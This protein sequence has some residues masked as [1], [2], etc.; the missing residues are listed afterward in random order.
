M[1]NKETALRKRTQ[2]SKANRTMFLWVAGASVVVG[3]AVVSA[4]FIVQILIFN[5]KV[6]AEK[7]NTIA[8]LRENN[9]NIAE[10]QSQVRA[11]DANASLATSKASETDQSLQVVLDALPSDANSLAL[12]A[13]LQNKLL[14]GIPGLTVVSLRVTPVFG[15]ETNNAVSSDGEALDGEISFQFS[16]SGDESSLR[17]ALENLEKS[18]RTIHIDHLRVESQGSTRV[19]DVQARAF[20]EPARVVEL[21]N[22]TVR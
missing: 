20:Y 16:V 11:L 21:R 13:S 15:V 18:I 3:A 10:L 22:K 17:L 9:K 4:I 7:D 12:G 2:I 6:L 5:E 14:A 19:L 1:E 8:T